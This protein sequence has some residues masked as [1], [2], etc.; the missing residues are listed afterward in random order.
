MLFFTITA[1]CTI[2]FVYIARHHLM[3]WRV[4]APK[5]LFETCFLLVVDW[6]LVASALAVRSFVKLA[7][8]GPLYNKLE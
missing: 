7:S 2:G 6:M 5:Y 1:T 3:V 4:F 8:P